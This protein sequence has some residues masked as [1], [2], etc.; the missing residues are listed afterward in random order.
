MFATSGTLRRCSLPSACWSGRGVLCRPRR[1]RTAAGGPAGTADLRQ[2]MRSALQDG[3]ATS[4]CRK[5]YN[6]NSWQDKPFRHH[7]EAMRTTNPR[8]W[9]H[10][11]VPPTDDAK[12]EDVQR[13]ALCATNFENRL[14]AI[15]KP[16]S[17]ES[18][19]A[20]QRSS[21]RIGLGLGAP[22]LLVVVCSSY[23]AKCR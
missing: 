3:S 13:T 20:G 10:M 17:S 15:T 19:I 4:C 11:G 6:V 21:K 2:C 12:L 5:L 22:I 7:G 1:L 8:S 18:M 16:K 23:M 9:G 14:C